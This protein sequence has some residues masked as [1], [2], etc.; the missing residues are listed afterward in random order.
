MKKTEIEYYFTHINIRYKLN[1]YEKEQYLF[2]NY[3]PHIRNVNAALNTGLNS[4]ERILNYI[5]KI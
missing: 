2:W 5:D 1:I 4:I 3:I